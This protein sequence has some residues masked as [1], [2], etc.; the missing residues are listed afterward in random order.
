MFALF[1]LNLVEI[2]LLCG[3]GAFII[4]V[5]VIIVFFATRGTDWLRKHDAEDDDRSPLS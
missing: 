5:A 3:L 4:V 1:G 2:L